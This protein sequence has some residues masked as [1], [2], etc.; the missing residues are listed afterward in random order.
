MSSALDR[1]EGR[2][3]QPLYAADTPHLQHNV[4]PCCTQLIAWAWSVLEI[5]ASVVGMGRLEILVA[6]IAVGLLG[7]CSRHKGETVQTTVEL[8]D[9]GNSLSDI[10]GDPGAGYVVAGSQLWKRTAAGAWA[11]I[12]GS[13]RAWRSVQVAGPQDVWAAGHAGAW[14]HGD[15]THIDVQRVPVGYDMVGIAAA[16]DA[17][18]MT[19]AGSGLWTYSKGAWSQ[20]NEPTVAD[21]NL[22]AVWA[23][24]PEEVFVHA[25]QKATGQPARIARFAKGSATVTALGAKGW[26]YVAAIHGASDHDVWAVGVRGRLF[27]KGGFASHFDGARWSDVPLPVDVPLDDVYERAPAD[28]WMSGK[29]GTVLHRDGSRWKVFD[30]GTSSNVTRIVAARG[31]PVLV[32]VGARSVLRIREH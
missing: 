3:W 24:S 17:A 18:F 10:D 13:S 8:T 30:I 7:A 29:H 31:G 27:G 2:S 11:V 32:I 26:S 21:S 23:A 6:L 28:V 20:R 14:G 9:T 22:G 5:S 16:G 15:A 4:T 19:A 12:P 25:P 1:I